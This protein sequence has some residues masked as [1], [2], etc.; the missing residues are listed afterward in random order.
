MTEM[1]EGL[2]L[3]A[4]AITMT[5]VAAFRNYRKPVN[6]TQET[7]FVQGGRYR[8]VERRSAKRTAG[9]LFR[10]SDGRWSFR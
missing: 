5:G 2:I 4:I 1:Y 10:R 6:R 3:A 9:A 8:G 7:T